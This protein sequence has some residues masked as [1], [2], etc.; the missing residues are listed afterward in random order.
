MTEI[1]PESIM[2]AVKQAKPYMLVILK[3]GPRYAETQDIHMQHLA[4][5]FAMRAAGQQLITLPVMDPSSEYVGVGVFAVATKEEAIALTE[6]DPAI[7][8]GRLT[9]EIVSC[10]GLPADGLPG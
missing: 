4:H 6:A 3:K 8:A 7:K 1:T 10:M 9:Y 2:A 5:I